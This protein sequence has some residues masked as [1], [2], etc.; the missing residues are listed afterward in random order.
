MKPTTYDP[1]FVR[2]ISERVYRLKLDSECGKDTAKR[3]DDDIAN[4][5]MGP[6]GKPKMSIRAR[7]EAY[8][9][10]TRVYLRVLE[11]EPK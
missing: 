8:D 1:E 11:I 2:D 10:I 3:T 9:K 4:G 5:V 7:A 6:N